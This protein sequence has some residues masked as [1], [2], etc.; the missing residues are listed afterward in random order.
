[1]VNQIYKDGTLT[2]MAKA[3]YQNERK[4]KRLDGWFIAK[5]TEMLNADKYSGYSE[6]VKKA[7]ARNVKAR[8][9]LEKLIKSENLDI[10]E[11]DIDNKVEEIAKTSGQDVEEFKKQ[12]NNEMVNRIAN[13]L[14]MKK[15]IDFLHANNTIK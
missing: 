9:V 6:E 13:E 15:L 10:T 12:V 1:M 7:S 11:Q 5:E 2:K 14:L 8:F 4:I 3:L